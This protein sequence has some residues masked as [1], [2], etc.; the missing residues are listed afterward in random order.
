MP[1]LICE[2]DFRELASSARI[3]AVCLRGNYLNR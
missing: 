2:L 3:L 1:Q